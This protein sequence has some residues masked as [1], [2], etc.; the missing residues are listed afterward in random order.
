MASTET[1]GSRLRDAR[2]RRDWTQVELARRAGVTPESLSRSERNRRPMGD[3]VRLRVA[4]AFAE[5]TSRDSEPEGLSDWLDWLSM[6]R[7]A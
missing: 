4:T 3:A 1:Q 5:T 6:A 7:K 2:L